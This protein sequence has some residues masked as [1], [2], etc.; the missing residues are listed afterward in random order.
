MMST[1]GRQFLFFSSLL[2]LA[3]SAASS[4]CL[5][6]DSTFGQGA[7]FNL[8][9]R[10]V[11]AVDGSEIPQA[12]VMLEGIGVGRRQM[13]VT[14]GQGRFYFICLVQGLYMANVARDGFQP[15]Q[16]AFD[17]LAAGVVDGIIRM[18]PLVT[19]TTTRPAG[20]ILSVREAQIPRK[21]R[22]AYDKGFE[23][24]YEKKAPERSLP[25]FQKAI[26]LYPDYDEAYVQLGIAQSLLARFEEAEKTFRTAVEV[27]PENARAHIYFGRTLNEQGR[28][29]E[30]VEELRLAL[31]VEESPWLWLAHLNL[32]RILRKQGK[33]KEAY[34]HASRAHELN[35]QVPDVHLLYYNACVNTRDY[36]AALAELDEFVKLYPE[37][38]V[39]K[40]MLAIR[41]KL[42]KEVA[43]ATN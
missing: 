19:A 13:A 16:Q 9:G 5:Q 29:E 21:A 43:P 20:N 23:E 1:V 24:L 40:K 27:H 34:V 12:T 17:L 31:E 18:Q 39:A 36:A 22:K 41:E 32:G 6:T 25:H 15:A 38:D 8:I 14:D 2:L 26:G 10:V 11:S 37:S 4:Q 28:V 42:A 33:A 30:A 3:A 7:R 35:T